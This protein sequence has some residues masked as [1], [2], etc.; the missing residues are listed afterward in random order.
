M[1][2]G[3]IKLIKSLKFVQYKKQ[4]LATITNSNN[5]DF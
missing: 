3:E 4:N 5:L 2:S 1:I